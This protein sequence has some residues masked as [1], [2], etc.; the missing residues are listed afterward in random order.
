MS[1][2][3]VTLITAPIQVAEQIASTL[4]EENLAACVNVIEK[5]RSVYRWEGHVEKAEEALLIVKGM[6]EKT[7]ELIARV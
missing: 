6:T 5:V 1:E 4:I 2:H 7:E 3:S